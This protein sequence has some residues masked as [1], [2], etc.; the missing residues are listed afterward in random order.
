MAINYTPRALITVLAENHLVEGSNAYV[1]RVM[2]L[3]TINEQG[4]VDEI[5]KRGSTLTRPD[6]LAVLDVYQD[7]II[8]R[9]QAGYRVNTRLINFGLSSQRSIHRG[10]QRRNGTFCCRYILIPPKTT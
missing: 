4:L 1:G 10:N 6:I 8:D 2:S 9:L 7:A 3:G 5:L